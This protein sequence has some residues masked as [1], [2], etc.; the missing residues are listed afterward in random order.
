ML[1]IC[2]TLMS[3]NFSLVIIIRHVHHIL[4]EKKKKFFSTAIMYSGQIK[5]NRD[6]D[7]FFDLD[8]MCMMHQNKR[9]KLQQKEII[10]Y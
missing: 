7:I 1:V 3:N 6:T 10:F 4:K 5:K 9:A 2:S 8:L